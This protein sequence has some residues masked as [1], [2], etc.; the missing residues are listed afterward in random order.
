VEAAKT[1]FGIDFSPYPH[2]VEV[3]FNLALVEQFQKSAA[4]YCPD[5]VPHHNIHKH[6][7]GKV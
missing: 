2:I 4:K 1:K 3:H 5:Y 7:D 6:D